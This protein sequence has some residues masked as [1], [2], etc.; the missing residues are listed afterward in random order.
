[1][2]K[3]WVFISIA[4]L[5]AI[6]TSACSSQ[7]PGKAKGTGTKAHMVKAIVVNKEPLSVIYNLSGTLQPY[8]ETTVSFEVPGRVLEANVNIGDSVTKG[9]VLTK[10]DP[11]NYL[12]QVEQ[13]SKAVLEAQAG[14]S[15]VAATIQSADAALKS[16]NAQIEA[17]QANSN[18]IKKGARE[19]E[20]AQAKTKVERAQAIHNKA[21]VDAKR[22]EQ[23]YEQGAVSKADY[24][25]SQVSLTNAMKDLEDAQEALS[26]LLEGATQEERESATA[27]VKQAQ[28]GRDSALASKEQATASL[29]QSSAIYQQALVSKKQAELSLSKT[30]LKAPISS[31]VLEKTVSVGQLVSSGQPVYRLGQ[32]DKLKVLL[33]VP[34][35]EITAWKKGQTVTINLYNEIRKGTVNKIYPA[36]NANTGTINVE[37]LIPNE[38]HKWMP[39]QVVKAARQSSGNEGILLPAEAI[40]SSGDKPFVYKEVNQK[41]TKTVVEVGKMFG[42]KLQ[43]TKGLNVGDRIVTSGAELLFEGAP[44]QIVQGEAK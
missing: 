32:I 15:N 17:A 36:A 9:Q 7:S 20:K 31:I 35:S 6:S 18:K 19:Q 1:M 30:S 33:P 29:E 3:R 40:I 37:V 28:S 27:N 2:N 42:S 41:A 16:A 34:D 25:A 38:D 11:S 21:Q 26:L 13:S 39:G 43:I 12:L 5:L 14:M 44:L 4:A 10:L 22:I 23:L 8:D 24:E